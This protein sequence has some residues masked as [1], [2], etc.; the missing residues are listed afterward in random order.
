[1][2]ARSP[3]L[4]EVGAGGVIRLLGQE[5]GKRGGVIGGLVNSLG[6]F[7]NVFQPGERGKSMGGGRSTLR[8][9]QKTSLAPSSI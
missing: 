1:M 6:G 9:W 5:R 4:G 3:R 7:S 2:P 8:R